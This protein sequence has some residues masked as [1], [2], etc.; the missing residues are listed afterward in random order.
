M[1]KI[2]DKI[3][4]Y[5]KEKKQ[6]AKAKGG[7]HY[8]PKCGKELSYFS[9]QRGVPAHQFCSKCRDVAYTMEGKYKTLLEGMVK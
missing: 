9:G 8:C 2:I 3:D 7:K 1:S 5:L 4:A 6:D